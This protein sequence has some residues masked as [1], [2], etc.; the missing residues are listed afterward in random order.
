MVMCLTQL[1]GPFSSETRLKRSVPLVNQ[2]REVNQFHPSTFTQSS[3]TRIVRF[4]HVT[5][6][7]NTVMINDPK[8]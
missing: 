4:G 7:S 3:T 2:L 8:G 6:P 1:K 5:L